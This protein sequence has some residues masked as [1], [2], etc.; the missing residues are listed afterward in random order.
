MKIQFNNVRAQVVFED[1]REREVF[2]RARAASSVFAPGALYTYKYRLYK[3]S[4]GRSGWNGKVNPIEANGKFNTGLVPYFVSRLWEVG[5]LI[6]D[7]VDERPQFSYLTEDITVDLRDYQREAVSAAVTNQYQGAWWPRGVIKVATGGGKTE[8]AVAMYQYIPV[9]TLFLVHRKDLVYQAIKRF[10][11]Y[12]ID[13]GQLGDGKCDVRPNGI[14]VATVQTIASYLKRG[15]HQELAFL[16]NIKQVF[17]DE[18]HLIAASLDKGNLFSQI[19]SILPNAFMRWGLTATPFMKDSYSNWLL[20]GATG[21]ILY[22][23]SNKTLIDRGYLTAPKVK[24]YTMPKLKT[25]NNTW[26][27]VYEE[28][29]VLNN[30]RNDSIAEI[31]HALPKPC[32]IMCNQVAHSAII[33]NRIFKKNKKIDI[34]TGTDDADTRQATVKALREGKIDAIICTTIFDEG[35]DIP[36]LRSIIMAGAGKSHVKQLQKIGRGLRRATGKHEVVVVDFY[37]KTHRL[38][39]AHSKK[40]IAMWEQEQFDI[41]YA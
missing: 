26:H 22:E 36:E 9:Q 15:K 41:S 27:T 17:F 7:L 20:A 11:K 25:S 38:L 40:R 5:K 32:L 6:P 28:G 29:I 24:V 8:M 21:E 31:F 23:I 18:S 10:E 1:D 33:H 4:K 3:K 19:S 2:A 30:K 12:G 14:T 34:L 13:A 16:S 39:E 35:V 37:D